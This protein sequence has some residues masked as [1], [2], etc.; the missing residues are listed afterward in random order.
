[1]KLYIDEEIE[2][3]MSCPCCSD[4][5]YCNLL[6]RGVEHLR[7][8]EKLKECPLQSISNHDNKLRQDERKNILDSLA[9]SLV[10]FSEDFT[11]SRDDILNWLQECKNKMA[12]SD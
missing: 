1:M 11:M 7:V 5:Y 6:S 8:N 9:L 4:E 3:C 2:D 12:G 10:E